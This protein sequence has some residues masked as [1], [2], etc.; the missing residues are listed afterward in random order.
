MLVF[1]NKLMMLMMMMM[2]EYDCIFMTLPIG[3]CLI[4]CYRA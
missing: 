2:I 4:L 3:N 1:L